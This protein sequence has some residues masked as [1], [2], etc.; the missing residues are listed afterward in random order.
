[1]TATTK[2]IARKIMAARKKAEAEREA[3]PA[4]PPP[5]VKGLPREQNLAYVYLTCGYDLM[6]YRQADFPDAGLHIPGGVAGEDEEPEATALRAFTDATGLTGLQNVTW[7][8]E[9]TYSFTRVRT[10]YLRHRHFFHATVPELR[11]KRWTANGTSPDGSGRLI[12][13]GFFVTPVFNGELQLA[14]ELDAY[15]PAVR[16]LVRATI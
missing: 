5:P 7:L 13:L 2:T 12:R 10:K 8:G 14:D 11:Q 4:V 15:L 3:A 9:A 6:V 1:M 16:T